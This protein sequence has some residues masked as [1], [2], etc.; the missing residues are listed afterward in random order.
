[1]AALNIIN[2]LH[3][4]NNFPVDNFFFQNICRT[5]VHAQFFFP[6]MNTFQTSWSEHLIIVINLKFKYIYILHKYSSCE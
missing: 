1:M 2:F 3:F 6:Q 4:K 5:C